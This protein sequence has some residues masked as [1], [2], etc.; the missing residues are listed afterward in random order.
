PYVSSL[1]L[2][3]FIQTYQSFRVPDLQNM[4]WMLLIGLTNLLILSIIGSVV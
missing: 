2:Q 3:P 1:V 4:I